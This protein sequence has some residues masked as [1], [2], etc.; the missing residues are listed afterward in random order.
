[1]NPVQPDPSFSTF[2]STPSPAD[3]AS[4]TVLLPATGDTG[5]RY[6]LGPAQMTGTSL[7]NAIAQQDQA[8]AWIVSYNLT[9]AGS[10][11]WDQVAYANFH[12]LVAIELDGV[13][14]S[15]PIIQPG[16]SAPKSFGG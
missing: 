9:G 3:L 6:I 13:V 12:G 1:M 2:P 16:A 11:L 15:A 10:A 8:G 14:Q 7:K 5:E 4:Q